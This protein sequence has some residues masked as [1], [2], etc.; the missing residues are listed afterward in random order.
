MDLNANA[1]VAAHRG[2]AGSTIVRILEA[3]GQTDIITRT[4]ARLDLTR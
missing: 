3:H 4:H 1:Y 2:M